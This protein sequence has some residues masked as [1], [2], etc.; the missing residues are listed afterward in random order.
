MVTKWME[1]SRTSG[2][3]A[4]V[5]TYASSAVRLAAAAVESGGGGEGCVIFTGGEPLTARRH[6]YIGAAGFRVFPR[7]AA[8][9]AGMLGGACGRGV[10]H[11]EVHIYTD[12]IA[13]IPG[14]PE[15]PGGGNGNDLLFTS[16]STSSPR[17]LL[18][19]S[20]GDTGEL[21]RRPCDCPF[22]RLGMDL[23]LRNIGS[24]E[25]AS[26][27][28][29]TIPRSTLCEIVQQVVGERGGSPDDSQLRITTNAEGID[30]IR[31]AVH[32]RVKGIDGEAMARE[33]RARLAEAPGGA[34]LAAELWE[35]AGT[36]AVVREAPRHTPGQKQPA[37]VVEAE[38]PP[39][40]PAKR[41][42]ER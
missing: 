36:I 26:V 7:Y 15:T 1:G 9:E 14:A 24:A 25:K 32:P 41:P 21:E 38:G 16:L 3:G 10:L 39:D 8:T 5:K 40:A 4:V 37:I 31:I 18:N 19:A 20:I 13:V 29:M 35:K 22:G 23:H 33:I 2:G 6:E 12:R 17:V 27:E 30:R 28:G 34:A 42:T 11:D